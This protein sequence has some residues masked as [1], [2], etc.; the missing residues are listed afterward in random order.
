MAWYNENIKTSYLQ[1]ACNTCGKAYPHNAMDAN[2]YSGNRKRWEDSGWELNREKSV[3]PGYGSS[4]PQEGTF[5]QCSEC[6]QKEIDGYPKLDPNDT[7]WTIVNGSANKTL[8]TY[9]H[10]ILIPG[11]NASFTISQTPKSTYTRDPREYT[12]RVGLK[13]FSL[14]LPKAKQEASALQ[15]VLG[16]RPP[17]N[18]VTEHGSSQSRGGDQTYIDVQR[19]GSGYRPTVDHS[20]ISIPLNFPN[21]KWPEGTW[22]EQQDQVEKMLTP[23]IGGVMSTKLSTDGI[24]PNTCKKCNKLTFR[25]ENSTHSYCKACHENIEVNDRYRKWELEQGHTPKKADSEC[26]QCSDWANVSLA[27][28]KDWYNA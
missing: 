1:V 14:T 16:G 20:V 6:I 17:Y 10:T 3:N 7:N 4:T 22:K 8:L 13:A 11:K 12:G 9:T 28:K 5:H 27:S 15:T 25:P 19:V 2:G 23:L 21:F 24:T 26:D 18:W